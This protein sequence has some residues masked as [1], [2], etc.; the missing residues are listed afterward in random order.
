MSDASSDGDGDPEAEAKAETDPDPDPD[1]VRVRVRGIYT[2]A[3]TRTLLT[4]GHEVVQASAPIRERFDAEFGTGD[5]DVAVATTDDR[6]GVVVSGPGGDVAGVVDV[7]RVARDALAW[8]APAPEGA[9]FDAHVTDARGGGA[10]CR[11]DGDGTEGYLPFDSAAGYVDEGDDLRVQVVEAAPPW[12][13]QR[14]ELATGLRAEAGLATLV[15]GSEGVRVDTHDDEAGRELAGMTD[16]LNLDVP[17]GWGLEWRHAATEA[18][19]DALRDSAERAIERAGAMEAVREEPVAAPRRVHAPASTTHVWFGRESRFALDE[20]RRAV[21]ATMP[22][23]HR[24]KAAHGAASAAVDLVEALCPDLGGDEGDD[25]AGD[26]TG[27]DDQ[28]FP[29]DVVARQFGPGAGDSVRLEHGK[30]D[31]R[32]IVLGD[33]DVAG[34]EAD[35]SVELRR[36]MSPGGTYDALG[37]DR[38]GGDVAITKVREGRWWYPTVYRDDEGAVKGTYVNVCTPVEVFPDAVRYVDLHVDVIKHADGTVE[39]VDDDELDAAV[40]TG[41]VPPALAEKA[42]AV[43]SSLERAL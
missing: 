11:L 43:A 21:T 31:G 18:G 4:A 35:G 34:V 3:C 8:A 13:N 12:A 28:E 5:H 32:L 24:V 23:H 7:L 2:T 41:D 20:H 19:M 17:D 36:E 38:E 16:L 25:G 26:A 6:Q 10:V 33:A 27:D 22:G 9:V 42:R 14:P 1:P 40:E 37:V 15:A 30:P 29:F 39:R